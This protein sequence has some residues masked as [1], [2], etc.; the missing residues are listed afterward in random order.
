MHVYTDLIHELLCYGAKREDRTGV[1]TR[2]LFGRQLTFDLRKGFPILTTK[3]THFKS[4]VGE[5]LWFLEG[6]TNVNDLRNDYGVTIWD[7][8]ADR[9][10]DLGPIYGVQ[11]RFWEGA[12][13]RVH[14]QIKTLLKGLKENPYSRRHVV[15]AWNVGELDLMA[16][17]PCHMFFQFYVGDRGGLSCHVYMR[18]CDVFLGLPFNVASYALLTH[19]IAQV[20]GYHVARL[21]FSFGDVHLY[22]N[23]IEQARVMLM[24]QHKP[25]PTLALNP[26]VS[27]LFAFKP[28]DIRLEGY[29]PHPRIEAKVAV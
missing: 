19:M 3:A 25:L 26:H 9:N 6:G 1:G 10:G 23:H 5:L 16:L 22:E 24:R 4:V 20:T 8:W 18:S 15:S 14:D 17:P 28:Q 13:G 2:S 21:V 11:W 12:D 7:E 27:D 29:D